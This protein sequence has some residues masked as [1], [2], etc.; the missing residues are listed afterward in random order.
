MLYVF[1][2][3]LI[4]IY[5]ISFVLTFSSARLYN[6]KFNINPIRI[7]SILH[8]T[9]QQTDIDTDIDIDREAAKLFGRFA[10]NYLLLD[11]EGAGSPE[12]MNCC[13]GGCDN[14]NYSH[15][16]D[17]MTSGRPKWVPVYVNRKLIDG[18][19]HMSPWSVLFTGISSSI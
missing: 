11:V 10:D 6:N 18:R 13:H 9:S 3:S 14:C 8:S 7:K 19:D 5:Q 15:I 1:C 2:S 12:M 17:N 4:F 16:F